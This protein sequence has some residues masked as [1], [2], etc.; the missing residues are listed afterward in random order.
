MN[1]FYLLLRTSWR[2]V[3]LAGIAGLF[4][5][6]STA[7]LIALINGIISKL[8]GAQQWLTWGFFGCSIVL[9]S[10]NFA[11][12][13]LLVRASQGAIFQLR[14]LLSERMLASPL[15]SLENIGNPQLLATLTDDVEWVSRSFAV[16]PA[17]FNAIAIFLGCLVYMAYLSLTAFLVL[18]GLIVF[19]VSSYEF[20]ASRASRF[21]RLA[22]DEQDRLFQHF[23]AV[24]DGNKELK[25]SRSRRQ[26][27]LDQQLRTSAATSRRLNVTGMT[28]FAIAASWGQ[29]LLFSTIGFF[30]FALPRVLN[31]NPAVLSGYVITIIYLMMP[32]QQILEAVPT[33]T[34]ATVALRKIDS[35]QLSL[36]EQTSETELI[37]NQPAIAPWQ[38]I[39]LVDIHHSYLGGQGE[40]TFTFTL[41]PLD[42]SFQG[43]ELVFIIG[44]NGSG[45][46]TLAKLLTGL[47]VPESGTILVDG[48]PI[49]DQNREWYRQHFSV[50]FAD[51]YLFDRLLGLGNPNL[52]AQA[53][54]Y[55]TQLKLNH[56]V[57]VKDGV[58]STTALSQGERKRLGLLNA[59]LEDRPI[60]LFDE[61]ASDQD[62]MFRDLF[63][64]QMLQEL[65]QRGKTVFVISHDDHYFHVADRMIKLD[66]GKVE[67]DKRA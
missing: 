54:A 40:Q 3:L 46:S 62:P 57:E 10:T 25:L 8:M 2:I 30:L 5:G 29:L 48:Q 66:Y 27:F 64:T 38:Q 33:L 19:G 67:Y 1:L 31:V 11:S 47:Y 43:G 7:G 56:K 63:Y 55:L 14:L 60:Y 59:Y 61:W 4:N 35:L 49:T 17:V 65:K 15:R 18:L 34:R 12:Q 28:M 23:R 36:A 52:D 39:Q 37:A 13:V 21:L 16:L 51:F 45:K 44:G 24:T 32:M 9:L 42:L 22:R 53:Q 50:V 58:L 26:A 20:L 6:A 41:G